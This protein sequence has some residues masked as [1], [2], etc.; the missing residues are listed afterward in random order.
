M[1]NPVVAATTQ[2][3]ATVAGAATNAAIITHSTTCGACFAHGALGA[4]TAGTTKVALTA[5]MLAHPVTA[6]VVVGG[7]A[8][9]GITYIANK[10]QNG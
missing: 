8:I 1:A 9:T 4:A 6:T 2:G 7:A 10:L 5:L 3:I